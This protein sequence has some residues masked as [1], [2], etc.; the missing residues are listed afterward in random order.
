MNAIRPQPRRKSSRAQRELV[1][2]EDFGCEMLLLLTL[3]IQLKVGNFRIPPL[4]LGHLL[5]R[6]STM[7]GLIYLVGLI[8]V[9]LAILAFFGLR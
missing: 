6:R 8:V 2:P 5:T 4:L 7:N 9:I 1:Q 3:R